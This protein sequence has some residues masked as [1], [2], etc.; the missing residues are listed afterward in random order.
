MAKRAK[1]RRRNSLL[2]AIAT[3]IAGG[4]AG[5]V[6][7]AAT[8]RA[9][10][11][12][13]H[14]LRPF[15]VLF[16]DVR[17]KLQRWTRFYPGLEPARADARQ[18]VE[19]EGGKLITVKLSSHDP[20]QANGAVRGKDSRR[21]K[22]QEGAAEMY[23]AFHGRAPSE[24][25][26]LQEA[27]LAA[28]DYTA[29]GAMGSL[30]LTPVSAEVDPSKW[31]PPS[32][33]FTPEDRVKLATDQGG[34]QLYLVGGNQELPLEYLERQGRDVDHR[35]VSLG[36]VHG[37]SYLTEKKFDGFQTTEYAHQFGEETGE[38]PTAWY[39]RETKRILLVGGAYSIAPFKAELGA[40][41]GI[42]N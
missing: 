10:A 8:Q 36:E 31:P 25:L 32:I 9:L 19:R 30:W 6:A 33:E 7:A 12:N 21:R 16:R 13:Q 17:G 15:E 1:T 11:K 22:N 37:I 40:S 34:I 2:D 26:E 39:D 27:L 41:P 20:R 24:V 5:G 14:G 3:G 29:L 18:A 23:A 42:V 38:R 35:F 28:G 4:A